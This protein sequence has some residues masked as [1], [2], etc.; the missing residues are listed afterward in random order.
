MDSVPHTQVITNLPSTVTPTTSPSW[1]TYTAAPPWITQSVVSSPMWLDI[2]YIVYTAPSPSA[3]QSHSA[4]IDDT[5]GAFSYSP[6]W[7]QSGFESGLYW[8]GTSHS[9]MYNGSSVEVR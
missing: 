5:S 6:G 1:A 4:T 9:T 2:D 8:N 7:S 3:A